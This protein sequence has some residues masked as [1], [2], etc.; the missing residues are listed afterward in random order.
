MRIILKDKTKFDEKVIE[1]IDGVK[2]QFFAADKYQ[3]VLGT[4]FVNKIYNVIVG[5][6]TDLAKV[7]D[8]SS[9]FILKI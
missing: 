2:G 4:G 5:N 6:G 8:K 1:N 9:D 3:I 7:Y